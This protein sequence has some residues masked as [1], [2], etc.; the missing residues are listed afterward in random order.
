MLVQEL[1]AL[2]QAIGVPQGEGPMTAAGEGKGEAA[3]PAF[4]ESARAAL[5]AAPPYGEWMQRVVAS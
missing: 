5:N 1:G 4:E 2:L 3:V